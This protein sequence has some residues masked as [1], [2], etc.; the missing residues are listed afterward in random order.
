VPGVETL[1]RAGGVAS[2]R[3]HGEPSVTHDVG[4]LEPAGVRV[5]PLLEH[6]RFIQFVYVGV[7][8]AS[9]AVYAVRRPLE[10]LAARVRFVRDGQPL[11]W[12]DTVVLP[13]IALAS[14]DV[15]EI[16]VSAAPLP[17]PGTYQ[18]DVEVPTLGWRF[19]PADAV[20][21]RP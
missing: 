19:T 16:A 5:P 4:V 2:F 18:V 21:V 6:H 12:N 8:N 1:A 10:P 11:A 9:E 7:H 3:L 17:E 13:P 15:A 20:T 14:E